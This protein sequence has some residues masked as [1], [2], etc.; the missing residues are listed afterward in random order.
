M[1]DILLYEIDQ[2][3]E[4]IERFTTDRAGFLDGYRLTGTE[5]AAFEAWDYGAL[6]A[7]G[8][9]P[10]LLFQVVRSLAVREGAA[11]PQII[12]EYREAISPHGAPDYIT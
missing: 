9:H 5:R 10:F 11:M 7:M 8:A 4:S 3:A 12:E 6:Y 1:I 2:T